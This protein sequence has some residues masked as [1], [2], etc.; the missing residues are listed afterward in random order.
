MAIET[1]VEIRWKRTS[2]VVPLGFGL[3]GAGAAIVVLLKTSIAGKLETV[4]F[5]FVLVCGVMGAWLLRVAACRLTDDSVKLSLT[6]EG[7]TDRRTGVVIRWTDFRGVRLY[8]ET[9]NNHLSLATMYVNVA[10]GDGCREVA[11]DVIDLDRS[12]EEIANLV[13]KRGTDA[14]L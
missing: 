5:G 13:Q 6:A 2:G 3:F 10:D 9:T 12:H 8:V 7:L 4:T 1:N 11:F 14:L